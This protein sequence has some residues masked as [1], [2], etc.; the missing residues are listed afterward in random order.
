MPLPRRGGAGDAATRR[1]KRGLDYLVTA[2]SNAEL[3]RSGR[4]RSRPE[5]EQI[6]DTIEEVADSAYSLEYVPT[7]IWTDKKAS[8]ALTLLATAAARW[9]ATGGGILG[10]DSGS[11]SATSSSSTSAA[12][13]KVLTSYG[14]LLTF[15]PDALKVR[16]VRQLSTLH[17]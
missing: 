12:W 16:S 5:L 15:L 2:A 6:A 14:R 17:S 8:T 11:T 13:V 3:A 10:E 9:A 4:I 1:L 7:Y